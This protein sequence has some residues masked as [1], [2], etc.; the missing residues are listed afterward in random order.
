MFQKRHM[1]AIAEVL[2]VMTPADG[3]PKP[4]FVQHTETVQEFADMLK[5]H[6]PNF[7]NDTFLSACKKETQS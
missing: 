6:N 1:A 5:R 3:M 7:K 4:A 2:R